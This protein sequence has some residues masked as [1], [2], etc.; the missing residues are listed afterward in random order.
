LRTELLWEVKSWKNL[1]PPPRLDIKGSGNEIE[2]IVSEA[3]I[4]N[5][6]NTDIVHCLDQACK[7]SVLWRLSLYYIVHVN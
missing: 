6:V 4:S 7:S 5:K 3:M 1:P 2:E